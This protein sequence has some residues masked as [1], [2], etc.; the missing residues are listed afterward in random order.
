MGMIDPTILKAFKELATEDPT[1]G[2]DDIERTWIN[3]R[4]GYGDPTLVAPVKTRDKTRTGIC[5]SRRAPFMDKLVE[6][7][8]KELCHFNK[9]LT[10]VEKLASGLMNLVFEDGTNSFANAV[11][12][13]DGI[14]SSLRQLAFGGNSHLDYLSFTRTVCYRAL[15]PM[16]IAVDAMGKE[17]ATTSEMYIG[18]GGH[19]LTYPIDRGAMMN[20]VACTQQDSWD[21]EAWAIKNVP[22]ERV[23]G[24]FSQWGP[25]VQNL[26]KAMKDQSVDL[27]SLWDSADKP[28]STYC[29]DHLVLIGDAAHASLPHQGAGAGQAIEDA[30][31]LAEVLS[32]LD[33]KRP[34]DLPAAFQAYDAMRRPRSQKVV[35]TSREVGD[36]YRLEGPDG[37]DLESIGIDL[38]TRL[39]WVWYEDQDL[40]VLRAKELCSMLLAQSREMERMKVATAKQPRWGWVY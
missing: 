39:N 22:F 8:P 14:R 3:F 26:L 30:L 19:I 15:V 34:A 25:H 31:V 33:V 9:R 10:G 27:W 1:E 16:H 6:Q 23:Q 35:R 38:R 12:G 29:K 4:L 2:D 5:G 37:D 24:T 7:I 28:L 18:P 17:L 20:V 36:V 32:S 40:Q 21:S 11:V 13:A